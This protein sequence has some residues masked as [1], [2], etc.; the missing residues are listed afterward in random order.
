MK[1]GETHLLDASGRT[2]KYLK[3]ISLQNTLDLS[4]QA[5]GI[6]FLRITLGDETKT[7]KI[8]KQ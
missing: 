6:Y 3:G 8:I 7:M 5:N 4:G 1:Q 2:V